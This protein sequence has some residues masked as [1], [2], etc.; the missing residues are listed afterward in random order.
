MSA[1]TFHPQHGVSF[2]SQAPGVG[3]F[4]QNLGDQPGLVLKTTET[5]AYWGKYVSSL[6][7]N[8]PAASGFSK[9]ASAVNLGEKSTALSAALGASGKLIGDVNKIAQ[10]VEDIKND[11]PGSVKAVTL[12]GVSALS[13][14]ATV[15]SKVGEFGLFLKETDVIANVGVENLGVAIQGLKIITDV[16]GIV[17]SSDNIA[18]VITTADNLNRK[19]TQGEEIRPLERQIHQMKTH[20]SWLGMLKNISSLAL[21]ILSFVGIILGVAFANPILLAMGTVVLVT[22][23]ALFFIRDNRKALEAADVVSRIN[24]QLGL[25]SNI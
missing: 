9:F 18:Q 7:Y 6:C 11:K 3:G 15:L 5:A 24:T 12:A 4:F 13:N 14:T 20:E 16:A 23:I 8:D 21:R 19:E 10:G 25:P 1:L 2:G 17:E 22:S